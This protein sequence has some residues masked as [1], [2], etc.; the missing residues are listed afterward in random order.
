MT[1]TICTPPAAAADARRP[2]WGLNRD[3]VVAAAGLAGVTVLA[4]AYLARHHL[5]P[6]RMAVPHAGAWT[7]A[8]AALAAAM[9]AVMMAAMML[10]TAAPMVLVFAAIG[11]RRRAAGVPAARTGAFVLGY[12]GVGAGFSVAA[13][14][15]EWGLRAAALVGG[16]AGAAS[17]A[18]GGV[19]LVAAGAYQL[20][21]L[22]D[23][24]LTGCRTPAGFILSEWRPGTRGAAVMGFRH[25]LLCLGCCWVLMTLMFVGGAMNLAWAAALTVFTLAEKVAPG[26]R[27]VK[28]ASAAG[29][30]T[31]GGLVLAGAFGP[32][33]DRGT[34]AG[35]EHPLVGRAAPSFS[36]PDADGRPVALD[37]LLARGPVV[38]VFYYGESCP[39][40]VNHLSDLD[41]RLAEYRERG[42][43]VVAVS[44][45]ATP[46]AGR[47]FGFPVLSDPDDA[48]AR[49]Y[50][51]VPLGESG[52]PARRAHGT[53]VIDR[54]GRVRWATTGPEP[55][56][57][58]ATLLGELGMAEE[59]PAGRRGAEN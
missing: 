6:G 13:A 43:S 59:N 30:V 22:K 14:L 17:P 3:V 24:C 18:L 45:D 39:H 52:G 36:L 40:C 15:A 19:L 8:D 57:E 32:E 20:S 10:P 31:W 46:G 4:W 7:P 37:D 38:L 53:F 29:L 27:T 35:G 58:H 51:V 42:A 1:E 49:R 28:W 23:A 44:P 33:P 41:G 47:G 5:G 2:A 9:W 26:R 54:A 48:V 34:R 55:F 50:G 12:L 21:P 25:G 16:V 56:A 11:R